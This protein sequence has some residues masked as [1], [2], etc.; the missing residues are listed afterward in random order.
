MT[1]KPRLRNC[2]TTALGALAL[3]LS[4]TAFSAHADSRSRAAAKATSTKQV[5][6]QSNSGRS[7]SRRAAKERNVENDT[8]VARTRTKRTRGPSSDTQADDAPFAL[9]AVASGE[10]DIWT[11]LQVDQATLDA[12]I[13]NGNFEG[14]VGALALFQLVGKAASEAPLIQAEQ[15]SVELLLADSADHKA[16]LM[17]LLSGAE[18]RLVA[19]AGLAEGDAATVLD[20]VAAQLG[21]TRPSNDL[22]TEPKLGA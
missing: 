11:A 21:F 18:A 4:A 5:T 15:A 1:S 2:T 16:T 7:T 6:S 9:A 13:R 14:P 3:A 10:A 8:T 19:A 22:P 20:A 17:R 12:H